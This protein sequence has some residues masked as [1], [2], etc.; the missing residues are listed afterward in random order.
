MAEKEK[1]DPLGC[2]NGLLE[3]PKSNTQLAP[4]DPMINKL[5]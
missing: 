5:S 1:F 4:N 3:K 2:E